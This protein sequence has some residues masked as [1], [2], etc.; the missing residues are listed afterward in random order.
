MSLI[1][2]KGHQKHIKVTKPMLKSCSAELESEY[3]KRK[4]IQGKEMK[5]D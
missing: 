3:R 2:S 4:Y 5:E 1:I